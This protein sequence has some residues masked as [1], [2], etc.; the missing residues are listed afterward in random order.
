MRQ[1]EEALIARTFGTYGAEFQHA[2]ELRG[3]D[4]TEPHLGEIWEAVKATFGANWSYTELTKPETFKTLSPKARETLLALSL[5]EKPLAKTDYLAQKVKE[6]GNLKHAKAISDLAGS[7]TLENKAQRLEEIKHLETLLEDTPETTK[8]RDQVQR[9]VDFINALQSEPDFIPTHSPALNDLIDGFHNGRLYLLAA[10]TGI[11]KTAVSLN[12]AWGLRERAKVCFYSLEMTEKEILGRLASLET[13]TPHSQIKQ[14]ATPAT[15]EALARK[16]L[17]ALEKSGLEII[18]PKQGLTMAELRADTLKKK[19]EGKLE[20]L[21]IDQFDKIKATGRLASASEY[22]VMT[23]H[24]TQLKQLA[25]EL[26]VPLVLLAQI[27][28]DGSEAPSLKHLKGSGQLEQDADLV[29]LLDRKG[30]PS[31]PE[32]ELSFNV[33]KNRHGKT[34]KIFYRWQGDLMRLVE[35]RETGFRRPGFNPADSV[36]T[37]YTPAGTAF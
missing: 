16:F 17:P 24:S 3:E 18:S 22:E 21:V 5:V 35:P 4:F 32:V 10:R 12:L 33:A 14:P 13:Q 27:N 6:Q 37:N 36:A 34:G 31:E 19:A 11:G 26:E 15:N 23:K 29:F 9:A 30:D 28:R 1:T 2:S 7:M 25:L 8:P 20:V